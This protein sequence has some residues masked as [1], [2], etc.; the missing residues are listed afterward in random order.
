MQRLPCQAISFVTHYVLGLLDIKTVMRR[1]F[2]TIPNTRYSTLENVAST[3]KSFPNG[4]DQT[5][6]FLTVVSY[7]ADQYQALACHANLH[8]YRWSETSELGN[9]S[10]CRQDAVQ[11]G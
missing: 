1:L 5:M 11:S 7:L 4:A 3:F 6:R 2:M 8:Q 9:C 10:P